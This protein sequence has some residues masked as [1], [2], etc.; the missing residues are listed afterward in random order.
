MKKA[1]I[2]A[3]VAAIALSACSKNEILETVNTVPE[4]AAIGFSNYTPKSLTKV[5]DTYISGTSLVAD[6]QFAVY[7]WKTDYDNF[8]TA[9]PGAPAFM[10]PA[11]VTWTN[12]SN[13]GANNT[14]SPKKYWP[15]GDTPANL[16]FAAY[17]PYGGAGIT[18]P[19]FGSGDPF[20]ASGVGTYAFT[21][22]ATPATMVDFCVADV[23]NDQVYGY[24]NVSTTYKNTVH[25]T[26]KHQLTKVQFKFK[27]I[28]GLAT[29]TVIELL[30]ADLTGI[31]NTGTLTATYEN[32]NPGVEAGYGK[33][34]T[35]STAWSAVSG[36]ASYDLTVNNVNPEDG[37][38]IK[39]TTT[40]STVH[41]N[42]IFLM[43]PQDMAADTQKL[44]VKWRVRVYDTAANAT[45]NGGTA[46]TGMLSET[47]NTKALSLY[48]NL[49]TSDSD[50]TSVSAINWAK[51]NFINYTITIGPKP[52]WFTA[53]V[54]N[55]AD[56]TNG[57]MN[58]N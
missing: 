45:A 14:Y 7:A 23:V 28:A 3:A 16:S 51:N 48:S 42:D 31:K 44:T 53:V 29:T 33:Q 15:S 40:A 55:W 35:T 50:D 58:V 27:T 19:T 49:V 56:M 57:Y 37:A 43:V 4:E 24:T 39:L 20:V 13:E 30:D 2:L 47:V 6:K 18:A 5:N 32:A 41:N 17:Y 12:N 52:I 38:P 9:N 10:N 1:L 11:V 8:L 36:S 46:G 54:D 25:F 26:F 34:G 21:A 22:Q